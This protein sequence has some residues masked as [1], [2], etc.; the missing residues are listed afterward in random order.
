ARVQS[1]TRSIAE[2][3]DRMQDTFEEIAR[4]RRLAAELGFSLDTG[5]SAGAAEPADPETTPAS[6]ARQREARMRL[7]R[8][9]GDT[10]R[11]RPPW[12]PPFWP[13]WR[14]RRRPRRAGRSARTS[15]R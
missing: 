13:R 14:S 3:G 11:R 2:R 12:H 10:P 5:Y 1:V 6:Q 8:T 4:E 7:A 9:S 15:S